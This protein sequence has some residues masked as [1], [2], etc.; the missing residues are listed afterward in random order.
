M[1]VSS[2]VNCPRSNKSQIISLSS[3]IPPSVQILSRIASNQKDLDR[4]L[5][6][7]DSWDCLIYFATRGKSA[8]EVAMAKTAKGSWKMRLA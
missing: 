4:A 2:R 3:I 8:V 7:L 6:A 5:S 1:S